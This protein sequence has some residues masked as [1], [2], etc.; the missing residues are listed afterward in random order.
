MRTVLITGCASGIGRHLAGCFAAV[1][2][3]VL[4][5][6]VNEA[7]L[8]QAAAEDLWPRDNVECRTMDVT[9]ADAWQETIYHATKTHGSLDIVLNVAGYLK[10][11]WLKDLDP[12]EI[13]RH[14][15]VN[16]KGVALGSMLSAQVMTEQGRGHIINIASL[17]GLAPIPGLGLYSASKYAVRSLSLSLAAEV[18]ASGVAVT[19]VCPDAVNTAMLAKQRDADAAALTF[20]GTVLAVEDIGEAIFTRVLPERP[21]EIHLPRHR[22][23]LA[24]VADLFPSLH[25]RLDPF[26][27]KQGRRRQAK[28]RGQP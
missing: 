1:G 27:R 23:A 6:D 4:A 8:R 16:V 22:G 10:P 2:E 7:G 17:A 14:F 5:T 26:L 13:D 25:G 24:R 18:K 21:L 28:Y 9:S 20:S 12:G 11:G 15:D 3:Q 19:V